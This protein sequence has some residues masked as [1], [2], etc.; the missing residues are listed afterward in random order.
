MNI[1]ILK[2]Q[3]KRRI[4]IYIKKE[5]RAMLLYKI[6]ENPLTLYLCK[7]SFYS[8]NENVFPLCL[9]HNFS[10]FLYRNIHELSMNSCFFSIL[11][12]SLGYKR[13][14]YDDKNPTLS[15]FYSTMYSQIHPL[16]LKYS[17]HLYACKLPLKKDIWKQPNHSVC[18]LE[19]SRDKN[20]A[21]FIFPYSSSLCIGIVR[22]SSTETTW[23]KVFWKWN[24][25]DISRLPR[26]EMTSWDDLVVSVHALPKRWRRRQKNQANQN[27]ML[28]KRNVFTG[29]RCF[30][31]HL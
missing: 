5:F 12:A 9:W 4:A 8:D 2:R 13:Q 18:L 22:N 6:G 27:R 14:I 11:L 31:M 23:R 1:K 26:A 17:I 7:Y 19:F 29:P 10:V 15:L 24:Y 21:M 28:I 25:D 3:S 20:A 16:N 30:F